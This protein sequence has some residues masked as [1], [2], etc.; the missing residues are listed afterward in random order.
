M[1]RVIL[2]LILK[3]NWKRDLNTLIDFPN[4]TTGRLMLFSN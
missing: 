4:I 3:G 2:G 1:L